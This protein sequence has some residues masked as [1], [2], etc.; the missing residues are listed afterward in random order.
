M[1]PIRPPQGASRWVTLVAWL[2][3][4]ALT[5]QARADKTLEPLRDPKARPEVGALAPDSSSRAS[6]ASRSASPISG[7]KRRSC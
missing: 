1:G 5:G 7:D 3:A 6:M 2:L 4:L